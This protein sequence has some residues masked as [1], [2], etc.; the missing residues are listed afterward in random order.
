[1]ITDGTTYAPQMPWYMSHYCDSGFTAGDALDP[2]CYA[3]YF[4]S[5]NDGFNILPMKQATAWP[6][7]FA[8]VGV[9]S[10]QQRP[11]KKPLPDGA[12]NVHTG[13]GGIRSQPSDEYPE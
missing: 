5:F 12:N 8:L 1:M 4:T 10:P 3:D 7:S 11:D 2:V 6:N 9:S 13:Y